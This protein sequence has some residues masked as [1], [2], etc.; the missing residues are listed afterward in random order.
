MHFNRKA[1]CL[2]LRRTLLA[3]S[4]AAVLGGALSACSEQTS[5]IDTAAESP[6]QPDK[7]ADAKKVLDQ[8]TDLMVNA[9]PETASSAGLDSGKYAH[10]KS[11]LTDRSP[12]GQAQIEKDVRIALQELNEI[13]TSTLR[14][15]D[16]LDV[17]VVRTMFETA[18]QGFDFEFGDNAMLNQNWSYRPS[19]YAVAQN[20]G[21]FVEIPSFLDTSHKIHSTDD[22]AA[23]LARLE[24]YAGQLDGEAE[25]VM[26]DGANGY[27]L[28]D[29]LLDKTLAQLQDAMAR[30][31][32]EW[33]L[34]IGFADRA[35][36]FDTG[37]RAHAAAIAKDKLAPAL[38]RR[39]DALSSFRSKANADAGIWAKPR[40]EEYYAWALRAG[41][42]TELS[43][44]EVHQLGL[45]ELASLQAR[46]EPI[47]KSI[48]YT[49]G[50]V[51]ERMAAY[52][53]H[54]AHHH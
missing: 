21:A 41:T 36:A 23:F 54:K 14:P 17:D 15:N 26:R 38:A 33:G 46:M 20:T 47:L 1:P 42:T 25:R 6:T 10:L 16:A 22:V 49:K 19:P 12:E 31:P 34:I 18:A 53:K 2:C 28:P 9:Y 39:I 43:P 40:G 11:Q 52:K 7:L 27:V 3:S 37:A 50:T 48:G 8:A 4:I 29:F 13:D 51:G 30:A 32:E 24:A 44:E 5:D 45:D 35:D